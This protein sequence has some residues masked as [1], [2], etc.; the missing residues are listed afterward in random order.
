[1][2]RYD[3]KT[4]TRAIER[5]YK[6]HGRPPRVN[7]MNSQH[8]LP[9]FQTFRRITGTSPSRYILDR[10]PDAQSNSKVAGKAK[11][12]K[13]M[14]KEQVIAAYQAF[15]DEFGRLPHG[16][17]IAQHHLPA[18]TT[19]KRVTGSTPGS[20]LSLPDKEKKV[21][22]PQKERK[23]R[24]DF[25]TMVAQYREF[26]TVYHRLP[27]ALELKQR[28]MPALATFRKATG[29]SPGIYLRNLIAS[30]SKISDSSSARIRTSSKEAGAPNDYSEQTSFV[31]EL[32]ARMGVSLN[33]IAL[34]TGHSVKEI[35]AVLSS[36]PPEAYLLIRA[37][38]KA[39]KLPMEALFPI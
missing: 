15:V 33:E 22:K 19:F 26:Y 37:I 31:M 3:E 1:M 17:E 2:P 36:P 32:I 27:T 16:N 34:Q 30:E 10:F 13:R 29:Q 12:D 18:A 11:A 20:I 9:T 21:Q 5:F 38:A 39:A 24:V 6:K 25:D 7:E 23:R 14:N 28:K 35:E 8:H 4:V